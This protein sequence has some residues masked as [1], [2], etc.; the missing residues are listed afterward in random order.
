[1]LWKK[2]FTKKEE[3]LPPPHRLLGPTCQLYPLPLLRAERR[4]RHR[5]SWPREDRAVPQD[6][7]PP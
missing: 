2:S 3:E 1:M 7:A 6:Q 5:S 4:G